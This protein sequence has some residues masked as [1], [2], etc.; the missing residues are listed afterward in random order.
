MT[1]QIR[2]FVIQGNTILSEMDIDLLLSDF[3]GDDKT[4]S[5]V[6]KAR[7]AL[8]NLYHNRGYP[9]VLVNIPEQTVEEGEVILQ[10]IE[11]RIRRVKISGNRFVTRKKILNRLSALQPGEVVY[12]PKLK[13]ELAL[14]NSRRDLQVTPVII[15]GKELGAI[16][17]ELRVKDRLPL[18]GS[19][20]LN[21]R[22]THATS[23]LRT[24]TM[25][26]YDDLWQK[27]HSIS[28]QY[29]NSPENM[30]EVQSILVSYIFS[31]PWNIR[32]AIA[33]YLI[34][35]DSE[36]T[37]FGDIQVVGKG[38][39]LGARYVMPLPQGRQYVHNASFGLDY[40]DFEETIGF[41]NEDENIF[42]PVK[43]LPLFLSY[44]ASNMDSFGSTHLNTSLHMVFRGLVTEESEFETKRYKAR[45]NYL[46]ITAELERIQ[47]LPKGAGL[48]WKLDGQLTNQ[49]LISNEQY[50]AGGVESIRGYKESEE[51]G[52]NAIHTNLEIKSPDLS[53]LLRFREKDRLSFHV[54]YDGAVLKIME[55]L[56]GSSSK[57][58]TF[59]HGAG[60][61]IRGSIGSHIECQLDWGIALSKTDQ[62]ENG[63]TQGYFKLKYQF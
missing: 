11:S 31:P 36:T 25:L 12:F 15:P 8:E 23:D 21:N 39:I 51:T 3:K 46:Y 58:E 54:F 20:E 32:H 14:V 43:Y 63:D 1:F 27:D 53:H 59:L 13:E 19:F 24:T 55:R 10:V 57:E 40:K 6:E 26:R 18:H 49:P 22:S 60:I 62:T 35:S 30:D 61:G 41:K 2:D 47:K 5:D 52:D 56:S 29:N 7:S 44:S 28:L 42:T 38:K 17:V 33:C 4:G 34:E 50:S 16:D 37:A 9:T 48:M 45:G